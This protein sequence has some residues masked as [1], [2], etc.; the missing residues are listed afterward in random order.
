MEFTDV[1]KPV[2]LACSVVYSSNVIAIGNGKTSLDGNNIAP[3][4]QYVSMKTAATTRCAMY[5]PIAD[6]GK[7]V[8]CAEGEG[9][10]S[11]CSADAGGP[12]IEAQNKNLVGISTFAS[13]S[14]GCN[15]SGAQAFTRITEY[16]PWIKKIT[17]I[18]CRK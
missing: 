16:L 9:K 4:L 17:G 6:Y 1:I 13:A 5:L 7:T 12:L 3:I 8:I 2:N 10:A 14:M 15:R 11:I 18:A